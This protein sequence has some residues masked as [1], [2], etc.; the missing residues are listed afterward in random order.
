M[1]EISFEIDWKAL[2]IS[3]IFVLSCF[4]LSQWSKRYSLPTIFYSNTAD[5]VLQKKTFKALTN[6]VPRILEFTALALFILAF[7]N[8]RFYI[9]RPSLEPPPS[10]A[11]QGIAIYMVLDQ[12]GSM[13]EAVDAPYIDSRKPVP[14][15]EILKKLTSAFIKGDPAIGLSGRPNDL[16]GLIEFARV[17][18]VVAPLTLD[19][20]AILDQLASF[21]SVHDKNIDGTGIGYAIY[22]TAHLIVATR[23]YAQDLAGKEKPAYTIKN[24]VIMLV[25]DGVQEVNP[26]DAGN[27]LRSMDIPD[28]AEYAKEQG[29]RLYIVNLEP[30]ISSEE[31]APFRHQMQN[32][33]ELTG[34]KFFFVNS[35]TSLPDIYAD[36]DLLEKSEIQPNIF[37]KN[38]SKDDLPSK[39]HR[40]SLYPFLIMIGMACL[41]LSVIL[42]ATLLRRIP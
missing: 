2:G 21:D 24:T 41:L 26:L 8:P 20:K 4:F 32:A 39:Y 19:H 42:N 1:A 13:A 3:L 14:K 5:L 33:A 28:A 29:V 38:L 36:I 7:I 23:H 10:E 25:T 16:I 18:Q 11:T 27:P 9:P 31:F 37:G 15:V 12:S 6:H 34:G 35:T 17:P 22:K 30:Q 40:I